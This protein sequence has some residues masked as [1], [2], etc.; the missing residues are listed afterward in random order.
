MVMS[1]VLFVLTDCYI[2]GS[3]FGKRGLVD[4]IAAKDP[5]QPQRDG[6]G[7]LDFHQDSAFRQEGC[8]VDA[9]T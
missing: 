2:S 5:D 1:S 9:V 4:M 3:V 6:S 8:S 7:G